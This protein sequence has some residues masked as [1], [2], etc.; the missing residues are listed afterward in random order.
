M[1]NSW[2]PIILSRDSETIAAS[3]AFAAERRRT[4]A[5]AIK[6]T[7]CERSGSA[8]STASKADESMTTRGLRFPTFGDPVFIVAKD[9]VVGEM[10]IQPR[11][12]IHTSEYVRNL[13]LECLAFS[14]AMHPLQTFLQGFR[15][16]LSDGLAGFF[17]ELPG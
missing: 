3:S 10:G 13:V 17:G 16:D 14:A 4:L 12:R 2:P 11:E 1:S 5:F 7:K 15:D 6:S 8:R 9:L